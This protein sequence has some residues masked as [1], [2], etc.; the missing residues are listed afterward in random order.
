MTI[1]PY[2]KAKAKLEAAGYELHLASYGYRIFPKG[3]PAQGAPFT[4]L[5]SAVDWAT[6]DNKVKLT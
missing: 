6:S 3:K 1:T 2:M 5:K 4:T